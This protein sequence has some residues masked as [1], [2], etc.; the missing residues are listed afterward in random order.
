MSE[1]AQKPASMK[2]LLVA[3]FTM[4]LDLLGFGIIIPIQPFYAESFGASATVVT[5]LG[6]TYSIMQF[7]FASFWGRLSD[8]LG[9]RPIIL[10]SVF[11]SAMGHFCFALA[12]NLPLLFAARALA[13]FGNANLGTAQAVVADVTT[14]ENR[15]KGMG[16]IGVAFGLG[17]LLGPAIGGVLGQYGPTIP[18]FAAGILACLN[19]VFAFFLLPETKTTTSKA[20]TRRILPVG[21]YTAAKAYPNAQN[22]LLISLLYTWGFALME[23]DITL[24]IEHIWVQPSPS[25]PDD[26]RIKEAASLTAMFLVTIGLTAVVVQGGLIGRLS[27]K[28]GEAKLIRTGVLIVASSLVLIPVIGQSGQFSFMLV[29]AVW[30]AIGSGILNPSK[31]AL[32]SRSIPDDRQGEILGLNQSLSSLG[33][34]LG[35][36]MAGALFELN[37]SV[38]FVIGAAILT[39]AWWYSR[40]LIQIQNP[41]H[42]T[43][44]PEISQA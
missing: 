41:S 6:A 29:L 16:L 34:V 13:G 4:F 42:H 27:K 7:F 15:A 18:L 14:Q 21:L 5:L 23:Q 40:P 35:P 12:P 17:F 8:R 43:D 37:T 38:P 30:M 44:R 33:R 11:I 32:L 3:F 2:P 20:S 10:F 39:L 28:V 25:M 22:L 36:L 9:R 1:D 31:S 26:L 19:W 24:Y